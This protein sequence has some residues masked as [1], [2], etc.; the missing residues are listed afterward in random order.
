MIAEVRAFEGGY[1]RHLMATIDG[2]TWRVV[3]F[4]AVFLALRHVREGWVIVD[5]AYGERFHEATRTWPFRLY[6]WAT[7]VRSAGRTTAVLAAAGIDPATV[8][9]VIVTHFHADHIG[10]LAEFPHARIHFR[11]E[12]WTALRGLRPLR[13]VRAAFLPALVPTDLEARANALAAEAF[14]VR[15]GLPFPQHDLFGD[16]SIALVD[17]PGH[18]PGQVG[19]EFGS[20]R[21]RELYVADAY[22]RRC[23]IE[24]GVDPTALAMTVQWDAA[25]YRRTI[26]E[27]RKLARRGTHHLTAC[28]D[29]GVAAELNAVGAG[30]AVRA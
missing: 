26:V 12:A 9:H 28:H 3:K 11:G 5:T 21:G 18:A 23:Q 1:C 14:V 22:W 13:Q 4:Q 20:A 19:L 27:L 25:A 6:R 8:R 29:E 17:L 7:P 16:G 15:D 10:G 24:G 2:C 30:G